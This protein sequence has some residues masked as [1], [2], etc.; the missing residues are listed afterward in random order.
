MFANWVRPRRRPGPSPAIALHVHSRFSSFEHNAPILLKW[1]TQMSAMI[2]NLRICTVSS[3]SGSRME[4]KNPTNT[5]KSSPCKSQPTN[6]RRHP[7][8]IRYLS[9]ECELF[10]DF[11]NQVLTVEA[12]NKMPILICPCLQALAE[13]LK[14]NKCVTE[15]L[16]YENRLATRRQGLVWDGLRRIAECSGMS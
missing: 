10:V 15:I 14:I 9:V 4:K 7:R 2:S 12:T 6:I 8:K 3:A 1:S 13:A 11:S 16:L 5:T